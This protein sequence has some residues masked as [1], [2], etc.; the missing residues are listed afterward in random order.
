MKVREPLSRRMQRLL[1]E[2]NK[3]YHKKE[4]RI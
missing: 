2:A 4:K 1:E 3:D